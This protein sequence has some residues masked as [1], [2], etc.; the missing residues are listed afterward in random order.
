[1]IS[2]FQQ[3]HVR[4]A[5]H[6][7][8]LAC[9]ALYSAVSFAQVCPPLP[10]SVASLLTLG[11]AESRIV[12][13][14]RD[15]LAAQRISEAANADRQTAG[16]RP[17]PSITFGASNINPKTGI[18]SGPLRDK[19]IDSSV[20][21]DQL[22]ERGDKGA[23][24]EQ[25]ADANIRST[26]ADLSEAQR[27]QRAQVRILFFELAYQQER[28]ER[29]RS[30]AELAKANQL[31]AE[32]RLAAGDVAEIEAARLRLDAIRSENDVRAAGTDLV[33][34]RA[35]LARAI[36]ADGQTTLLRVI[37]PAT[38][39]LAASGALSGPLPE[40]ADRADVAAARHRVNAAETA[41]AL[42]RAI[43]TRDVSI[44]AQ[45]DRWPVSG[46][47]SQG[48]GNSFGIS[49]T[50]P[51][52]VR[53]ANEGEAR[54]ASVDLDVARDQLR[55]VEAHA[56]LDSRITYEVWWAASA[57]LTQLE[58]ELLPVAQRIAN[59]AEF[60]YTKRAISV[61]EVLDAR[62]NLKSAELDLALARADAGKAWA[63]WAAATEAVIAPK[64]GA[65]R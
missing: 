39:P 22:I 65:T 28:I 50:I 43:A 4:I 57:R 61:V 60:A 46:S 63:A 29:M 58:A 45:F 32:K 53:H 1:M 62:R 24:R 55:R 48:T 33:R 6:A 27:Q 2:G 23:L 51:L 36:A 37:A 19:T 20:R 21:I 13:C 26:D 38:P 14:N 30:F 15:V 44:G 8:S 31:T 12:N 41:S 7:T 49:M 35:D 10:D 54:R 3:Q 17:N 56:Q 64:Y 42:A 40:T 5:T 18:G 52:L 25:Q 47:N 16:Q 9:I 11:L 34:A 59:A